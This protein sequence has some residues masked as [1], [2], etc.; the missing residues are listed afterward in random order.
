MCAGLHHVS[1]PRCGVFQRSDAWPHLSKGAAHS[2]TLHKTGMAG[3]AVMPTDA[4]LP[5]CMYTDPGFDLIKVCDMPLQL[6]IDS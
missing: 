3:P 1:G 6:H 5:T 4:I 2:V